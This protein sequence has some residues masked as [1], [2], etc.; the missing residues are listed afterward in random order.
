MKITFL[1]TGTSQGVPIIGCECEVCMSTDSRD[2]RLRTS[3]LIEDQGSTFVIDTGPDFRQQMLRENIKKLDAVIFTH[4][5][6]DHVAGLDEV[7]A[8]NFIN[9]MVMPVYATERV[10]EALKREFAYIF[11][12][13]KYPGIPQVSLHTITGAAFTI[14]KTRFI[15][16]D[17]VHHRLPVKAFRINDFTYITDANF[18]SPEEKEKIKGSRVLVVNALRRQTHISHFTLQ[19]AIELVQ[20]LTPEQAYFIHISHQMGKHEDVANEL[21]DRI[22]LAYD[23]LKIQA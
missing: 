15:P 2:K 23:G 21:P 4:E 1:G 16:I 19:Q 14:D 20:E 22:E 11:A 17:V 12:D 8:F 13:E 5:H 7:R 3:I 18:I 9:N 10:Q 6:K